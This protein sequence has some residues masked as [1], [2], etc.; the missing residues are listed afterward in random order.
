MMANARETGNEEGTK[1]L[2]K[3]YERDLEEIANINNK[4]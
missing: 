1:C 3:W 2:C 4:S